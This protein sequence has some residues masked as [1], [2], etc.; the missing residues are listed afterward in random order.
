MSEEDIVGLFSTSLEIFASYYTD[1]CQNYYPAI[2][3]DGNV[4][5][6]TETGDSSETGTDSVTDPLAAALGSK[7]TY[8]PAADVQ[9]PQII[10]KEGGTPA[11][12]DFITK[13]IQGYGTTPASDERTYENETAS[14]ISADSTSAGDEEF[15]SFVNKAALEGDDE[16]SQQENR[17]LF[18]QKHFYYRSR[19]FCWQ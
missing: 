5:I 17:K 11:S 10:Y 2:E 19:F 13:A 18:W 3:D 12:T 6:G 15:S 9:G 14:N 4:E 16:K 1:I 7:L 8:R